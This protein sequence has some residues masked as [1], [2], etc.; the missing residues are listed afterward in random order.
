MLA[1]PFLENKA[2]TPKRAALYRSLS[3][4]IPNF[5]MCFLV[6]SPEFI[7]GIFLKYFEYAGKRKPYIL[8]NLSQEQFLTKK[9]KWQLN[10]P[11]KVGIMYVKNVVYSMTT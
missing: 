4:S 8:H 10:S 11:R 2:I 6:G 9:H 5:S 1:S 7:R 3:L